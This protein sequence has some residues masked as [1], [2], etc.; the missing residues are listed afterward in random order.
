MTEN[1]LTRFLHN[2][3]WQRQPPSLPAPSPAPVPQAPPPLDAELKA[4]A[5][6]LEKLTADAN[7]LLPVL[8]ARDAVEVAYQKAKPLAPALAQRLITLDT[9]LR[10]TAGRYSLAMLPD[11]RQTLGPPASAWWW[12]LD[13]AIQER[14][15]QN[16]LPWVLLTGTFVLLS[17]SL[18]ADVLKRLWDGAP[19][20]VSI[21]GTLF[22]LTLTVS[23]LVKR[24]PELV[25]WL[26]K[27]IPK[28][29][30][31]YRGETQAALTGLA[32]AVVLAVR[33]LLVPLA[34]LYNNQGFAALQ[35]DNLTHAQRKF[36]RAVALDPD[37][38]VAAYNLAEIYYRTGKADKAQIW[39]EYAIASDLNFVPSYR[40]LGRLYNEQAQYAEAEAVLR[41]GLT[42]V[43]ESP[44]EKALVIAR[45]ELLAHLGWAYFAQ[46]SADGGTSGDFAQRALE[47][48]LTLEPQI[49]AF[50]NAETPRAQ[51]RLALPHYYLAQRYEQTGQSQQALEQ[52]EKTLSLLEPGWAQQEW[53]VE[54]QE[55]IQQLKE[56]LQ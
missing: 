52:W 6:A 3:T 1:W 38:A 56:A 55:H 32:F 24:G 9:Q 36:Q 20:F 31:K 14:E 49:E 21:F 8:F 37:Q 2:L 44:T 53:R 50:E 41:T 23:P 17:A 12:M 48:S 5:E 4:Y 7:T 18:T 11:W 25:E 54:A 39:Y 19:D 29:K 34:M 26:V 47:E 45:Y 16:D 28:L 43:G 35:A 46:G 30:L 51:Y 27:R 10:K 22:T 40:G 33:L 15:Q 13:Q 42:V